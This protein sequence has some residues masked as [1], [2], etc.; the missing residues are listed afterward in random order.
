[1]S[2]DCIPTKGNSSRNWWR[3]FWIRTPT[4]LSKRH[5]FNRGTSCWIRF[6]AVGQRSSKRTNKACTQSVSMFRHLT[7]SSEMRRRLPTISFNSG[8]PAAKSRR[9]SDT[10]THATVS[11]RLKR[12]WQ[13]RSQT[14]TISISPS[15]SKAKSEPGKSNRSVTVP[16][17]KPN[18]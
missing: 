6:V 2:T 15:L 17:R 11:S 14:L 5:V 10:S 12:N 18:F 1:M 4:H 3:I 7:L 13:K 8:R 9:H 16:R